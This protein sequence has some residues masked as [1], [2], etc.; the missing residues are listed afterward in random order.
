MIQLYICFRNTN[1]SNLANLCNS[2]L[3]NFYDWA[4]AN[5]LSINSDKTYFMIFTHRHINWSSTTLTININN[6]NIEMKDSGKFLG[7]TLDNKLN[8]RLHIKEISTKI[9]RSIGILYK[10]RT[11]VSPSTLRIVYHSLIYSYLNYC[12][13]V[14]GGTYRSHLNPLEVLQKRALRIMCNVPGRSHTEP[15]FKSKNLLKLTDVYH[16][17]LATHMYK[18]NLYSEYTRNH[19]H[20]TR[21]RSNLLPA[22]HRLTSTQ[23]SFSFNAP[24]VWNAIPISIRE[25]RNVDIFKNNL[26]KH[27]L[28]IYQSSS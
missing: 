24:N 23:N 27:F 10:L 2:E 3:K 11:L 18:N 15:L 8:F 21:N 5:R 19:S 17:N 28:S 22:Y 26:K 20:N 4:T 25:S 9:S 16:Y 12:I 13:V 1:L 7:I 6:S 14:W